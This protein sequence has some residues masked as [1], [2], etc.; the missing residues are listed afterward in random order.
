MY[1][2]LPLKEYLTPSNVMKWGSPNTTAV[3]KLPSIIKKYDF[4]KNLIPA[5]THTTNPNSTKT[6]TDP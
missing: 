3:S 1:S 6:N 4:K 2:P 5:H